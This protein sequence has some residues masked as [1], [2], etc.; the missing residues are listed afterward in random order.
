MSE[1]AQDY[2]RFVN[3]DRPGCIRFE[4]SEHPSRFGTPDPAAGARRGRWVPGCYGPQAA[5]LFSREIQES[6][7]GLLAKN[8]RLEG[9]AFMPGYVTA[10]VDGRFWHTTMWSRD[11][12]TFL[13][14]L[15]HWGYFNHACLMADC[16]IRLVQKNAE[17]FYS[18]PMYF[19]YA[20][21]A[22]GEELDGSAAVVIGM[23]LL[24]QRLSAK[25]IYRD[26]VY[27]FLHQEASPLLYWHSQLAQHRFIGGSGEFGGGLGFDGIYYN[28]VQNN[29]AVLALLAGANVEEAAGDPVRAALYRQDAATLQDALCADMVAPDGTWHWCIDPATLQANP[30]F[31]ADARNR[32][33]GGVN[34][35]A[36]MAADVLGLEVMTSGWKGAGVSRRTF[37][38]LLAV[39]QR[40]EQFQRY[41]FWPQWDEFLH[42]LLSSPSSGQGYAIQ[43][44]LLDDRLDLAAQGLNFLAHAT[45]NPPPEYHLDRESPYHIYERYYSPDAVGVMALEEGCGA[46][47]LVCVSEPLKIARLILGMDDSR[48]DEVRILPRLPAGWTRV[49]AENWPVRTSNGLVRVDISVQQEGADTRFSLDLREGLPIPRLA[50]RLLKEQGI[51]WR[52]TQDV[53]SLEIH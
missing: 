11:A 45:V 51:Q 4:V 42:G 3:Q 12:G 30:A 13:R 48:T 2:R 37:D 17:G 28:V 38:H 15:V 5:E 10:S 33:F 27:H 41:G 25:D 18:Y 14:E 52:A 31:L 20:Q 23:A 1:P 35:V 32:G 36:S 43:T 22:S 46:L 34:G 53:S 7:A 19:E 16:L 44:M 21:P 40:Q 8:Y 6:F 9:P 49:E 47:N 24:W 26:K 50:V 29:L 39:P